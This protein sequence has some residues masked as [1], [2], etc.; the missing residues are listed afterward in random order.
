MKILARKNDLKVHVKM[1][2]WSTHEWKCRLKSLSNNSVKDYDI[3]LPLSYRFLKVVTTTM[4][5]VWYI[6]FA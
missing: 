2:A 1:S 3:I 5:C 4:Q 6:G